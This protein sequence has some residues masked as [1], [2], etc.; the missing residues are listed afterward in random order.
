M[1]K[2]PGSFP[3]IIHM[4]YSF[5]IKKLQFNYNIR[6][7]LLWAIII[8]HLPVLSL[9]QGSLI[10]G[11][12]IDSESGDALAFVNISYN[13][14]GLGTMSN[15]DGDFTIKTKEFIHQ[16]NFSYIGY[17]PVIIDQLDS[18]NNNSILVRMTPKTYN[19]D[20]VMIAPGINPAHRI[21]DL[22]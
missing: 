18:L 6:F 4:T 9:G 1:N 10:S 3:G 20:E 8:F 21:I 7:W 2:E 16:L 12:I 22:I 14:S 13:N 15:I 5:I 17:E 11:K 19:I